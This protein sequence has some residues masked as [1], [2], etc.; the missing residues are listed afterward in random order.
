MQEGNLCVLSTVYE[1]L[2]FL[3]RFFLICSQLLRLYSFVFPAKL[4]VG[5]ATYPCLLVVVVVFLA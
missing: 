2:L 3:L 4:L 5:N 1:F